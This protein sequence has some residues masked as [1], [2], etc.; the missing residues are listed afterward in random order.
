MIDP[1]SVKHL[2]ADEIK[3]KGQLNNFPIC[4]ESRA[5]LEKSKYTYLFPI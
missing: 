4:K 2:N 3:E 1:V 5:T